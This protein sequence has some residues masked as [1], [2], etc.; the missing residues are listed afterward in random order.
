MSAVVA[1]AVP[2]AETELVSAELEVPVAVIVDADVCD[3]EASEFPVIV[4]EP[5]RAW[6]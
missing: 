1:V 2:D 3:A 6:S 4:A 5:V